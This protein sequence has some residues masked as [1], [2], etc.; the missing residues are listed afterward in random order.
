VFTKS[1]I[2]CSITPFIPLK[3]NRCF[4]GIYRFQLQGRKISWAKYYRESRWQALLILR[5]WIWKRYVTQKRQLTFNR[6]QGVISQM[7][8]SLFLFCWS[9]NYTVLCMLHSYEPTDCAE[10]PAHRHR[11]RNFFGFLRWESGI[12]KRRV[13][14]IKN[15]FKDNYF[16]LMT[17]LDWLFIDF[18]GEIFCQQFWNFQF[19]IPKT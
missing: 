4:G 19:L 8:V 13:K 9:G 2:F 1:D 17:E 10:E 7:I 16:L 5:S 15:I 6:L 18:I 14:I 3:V 11:C 12:P